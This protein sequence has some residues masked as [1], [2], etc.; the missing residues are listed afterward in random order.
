[1]V[2]DITDALPFFFPFSL[3]LSSIE[4]FHCYKHVLHLSLF[5]II[6]IFVYMFIFGSSSTYERK[7][8]SFVFLILAYFT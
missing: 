1:M 3:S 8:V 5:T 4:Q 7:H 6:L 2:C